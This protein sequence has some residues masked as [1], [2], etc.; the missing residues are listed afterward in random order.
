MSQWRSDANRYASVTAHYNYSSDLSYAD[1]HAQVGTTLF[2]KL[3]V[4]QGAANI[5]LQNTGY[6]LNIYN[7][8]YQSYIGMA[9]TSWLHYTSGSG[10][11]YFY[12]DVA[13]QSG[14]SLGTGGKMANGELGYNGNL[15]PYRNASYYT[16]YAFV[17][18][19]TPGTSANW[20]GGPQ[21]PRS[22]YTPRNLGFQRVQRQLLPVFL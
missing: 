21:R 7:G 19:T 3:N 20:N 18:L 10:A 16:A 9:N 2:P 17:P 11:H 15:R 12:G 8:G 1:L 6:Y 22:G 13:I 5:L 4:Q 14:L